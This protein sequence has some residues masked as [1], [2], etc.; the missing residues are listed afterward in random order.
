MTDYLPKLVDRIEY[1]MNQLEQA[2]KSCKI[3]DADS[4]VSEHSNS[5]VCDRALLLD[6][7]AE[8]LV[9]KK[10]YKTALKKR[11]KA[12]NIMDSAPLDREK[13][14]LRTVS[15]LSN[16]YNNLSNVYMLMKKPSEAVTAL[17]K[18]SPFAAGTVN[19]V[20]W[21]PMICYNSS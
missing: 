20:S 1:T 11:Q 5:N 16:L 10:D 9:M 14:D 19:S 2:E 6:Y 3:N 15:L 21:N 12:I 18:L 13:A 8:L 4:G 17:E 7:K